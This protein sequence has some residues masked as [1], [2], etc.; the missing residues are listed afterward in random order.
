MECKNEKCGVCD[1]WNAPGPTSA[2]PCLSRSLLL[3][4]GCCVVRHAAVCHSCQRFCCCGA[5]CEV[6]GPG[7]KPKS[8]IGIQL[9]LV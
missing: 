3:C 9:L 2:A 5:C 6:Q 1:E 4:A 8:Q 7:K